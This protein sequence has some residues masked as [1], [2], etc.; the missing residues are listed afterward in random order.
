MDESNQNN[1]LLAFALFVYAAVVTAM[2]LY[3]NNPVFHEVAYG[4]LAA[5][6]FLLPPVQI[7]YIKS[8]YSQHA[9]KISNLWK[10]YVYGAFSFLAGFAIWGIDN[11][12]CETLRGVRV[13]IGYPLRVLLEFH[14]WWHLGTALGTYSSVILITYLRHL[15][16][17]REDIYVRWVFG[18]FPVLTSK[19]TY[20][21]IRKLLK[22]GKDD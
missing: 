10:I 1:G 16:L 6:L 2:Y 18:V 14:L 11:N 12:F 5:I 20:I 15:A 19:L 3:L 7:S 21:E 9:T 17:G 4:I 8:N 13:N 22:R